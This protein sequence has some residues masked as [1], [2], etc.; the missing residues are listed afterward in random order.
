[1]GIYHE[2]LYSYNFLYSLLRSSKFGLLAFLGGC[3]RIKHGDYNEETRSFVILPL[4]G[5]LIYVP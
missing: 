1:M 4:Y 2:G 5:S 3:S